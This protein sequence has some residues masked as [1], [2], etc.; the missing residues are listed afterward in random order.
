MKEGNNKTGISMCRIENTRSV[1]SIKCNCSDCFHSV[2]K[3]STLYCTQYCII[4]PHKR[5]CKRYSKRNDYA[6][7]SEEYQETLEKKRTAEP[8]FPWERA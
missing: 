3:K 4:D 5:K 6:I 8:T 1:S 7:T 2:K